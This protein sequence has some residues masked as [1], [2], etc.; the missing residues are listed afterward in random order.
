MIVCKQEE[1]M[2]FHHLSIPSS[3]ALTRKLSERTARQATTAR[4]DNSEEKYPINKYLFE[5]VRASPASRAKYRF[6]S[7]G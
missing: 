1:D 5:M 3:P 7:E 4:D 2:L 6:K